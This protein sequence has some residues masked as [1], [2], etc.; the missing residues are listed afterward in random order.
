MIN[1]CLLSFILG[2]I[3]GYFLLKYALVLIRKRVAFVYEHWLLNQKKSIVFWTFLSGCV[4]LQ[5]VYTYGISFITLELILVF[6]ICLLISVIDLIIKKIPNELII[7]ILFLSL[8]FILFWDSKIN[9]F[10]NILGLAAGCVI[11]LAPFILGKQAGGGDIKYAASIGFCLGL[12][13]SF[14][15][16]IIMSILFFLYSLVI[17]SKKR[18]L[19]NKIA[20]GPYMSIGFLFSFILLK[21]AI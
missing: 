4:W 9:I 5:F 2:S 10:D 12:Y 16:F 18:S 3:S 15:A 6:S 21:S 11:F 14:I 20:M 7:S 17:I 19:K 8:F 1:I 13:Y